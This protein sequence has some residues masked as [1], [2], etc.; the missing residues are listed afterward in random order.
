MPFYNKY[1]ILIDTNGYITDGWSDGSNPIKDTA[2][3]ICINEHGSHQFRLFPDGE[4]NPNLYTFPS[5]IPLY[6]YDTTTK[7]VTKRPQS[8]IDA[9][10]AAIPPAP[11]SPQEQLRADVDYIA[12]ISGVEL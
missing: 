5:L 4:E 2:N 1:Y 6:H 3:A 8:E 10:I 7:E 11:P 12:A 9:A